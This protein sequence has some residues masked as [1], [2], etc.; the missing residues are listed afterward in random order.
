MKDHLGQREYTELCQESP[1]LER[2]L[3]ACFFCAFL[4][5]ELEVL[6]WKIIKKVVKVVGNHV[7]WLD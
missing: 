5:L 1:L 6:E 2:S 3:F 4:A 7:V